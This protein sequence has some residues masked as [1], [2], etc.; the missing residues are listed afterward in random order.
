LVW[1]DNC[2]FK[3]NGHARPVK[4]ASKEQGFDKN[5]RVRQNKQDSNEEKQDKRRRHNPKAIRWVAGRVAPVAPGT[6]RPTGED[7]WN[8]S[9]A[10]KNLNP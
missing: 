2:F 10:G 6:F 7:G 9:S 1:S 3:F 5:P 4:I 8:P